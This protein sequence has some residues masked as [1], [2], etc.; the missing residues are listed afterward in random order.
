MT[1]LPAT[2]IE[3]AAELETLAA[4]IAY[5]NARYHTDDAPEISDADYDALVRRNA[6]IE[7]A[8]PAAVRSD[9]PSRTVG[10]AP[11][12][13]L[14]KVAH[15]KAMMSLDNA[16]ADEEVEEFV[17]RVRRFLK[18]ADDATV[19][20]TAEPKIDGLSCSLRYEEGRLVQALTRGDGQVGEDVT[21]NVRTISDIPATL[22][23]REGGSP[24]WAPA[25]AGE[26]E[27]EGIP[28]VFEVRGEV[29][30][31][32]DDFAALNAR[33]L[34]DA[35]ETG[36]DARQFA[37]PRNAAAGSL[38]QK[39]ASVTASRTLRF[40]AHGWGEAS[41]VPGET[42]A[43][44]VDTLRG[45]GFPIAEGFA[46]VEGTA[47]ALDVYRKIEAERPDL[48]F[49]I[50][51]VVYKVDR[52]DWQA[53][54]GQVAKAP[55]WAIAHKFP[56]ERAQTLLEKIDI[57][58]GRTGAMT[59]V[60]RLSPVTVG[61][62]V[63][64]NATLHNADEIERLGVRPGDRV[65]VQRA[66]DVI[67]QIVENLTPDA[68]REAYVFPH[69]CPECG[70]AAER[71]E[72]EVVYR[73][74]GGLICPAQRV[75]RLIHFASRHA[76]DIGGLGQ[77]LIEAFFRDGLIESPADI[78][79][80]TEE[81]LAARKKDGRVWA[82]KVI[83]AIETKRTIPLDRFLFSLGIRHVGEITARDL[84]RR[85]VSARALSSVL[86]HAVFLRTQIEPVI[87][88]PERKFVLRRDKLLVGAI[89]TAGIGPEVASALIG[90][91][92]E[93]H[94][95]RVV[96]DLLREVKPADVVH[97]TRESPVTGQ[98]LVFT[99]SL[100]TLSR[101]EAKAQAEALGARVAAS[102]SSKTGL[103]IAGPG[104]GS[105]LKKATELGI[106]V[107]TEA[108]WAEIVAAS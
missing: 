67:P 102:V 18:L 54:L 76:F 90:F 87:G 60:A 23:F 32:K 75:E 70:S 66:G 10:A 31:A 17:A 65:L 86:R 99:G 2:E 64:T 96:F 93:P 68:E 45:W 89:E 35:E 49:D 55:R 21:A 36:K 108:E 82:A 52:L 105:K 103:V 61:G 9:S 101:D 58:V 79:R 59:P 39:D 16:F 5:H 72:G 44:V 94:N 33:L 80:L 92:A 4:Q 41:V 37:N 100:E 53:R 56:A 78:F 29:Y 42:Q 30:M 51:G 20:L 98:I 43:E 19:A 1:D 69:V 50:D 91:C 62:V 15:A 74:T 77:T 11:A 73:C 7:A 106:R 13:H 104:A 22:F 63:V 47:A 46:R 34:A 8:F 14:A 88:E 38:R 48:P 24:D 97:E 27:R 26:Q 3:A 71:E 85:Y 28:A 95:R 83:A 84:A 12:G 40:L 6:A 57:Q 81:Q 107:I 25:F